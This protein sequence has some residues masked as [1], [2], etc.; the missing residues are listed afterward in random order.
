MGEGKDVAVVKIE[1]KN[2]PTLMLG[3]SDAM[4]VG[5]RLYVIGYPAA[6][7]SPVL[8]QKS[9]LEP[10]TNDGHVSAKKTA[11][12]GAPILQTNASTTHG[13]SGGPVLNEKGEVIGLLTFPRRHREQP[14][15]PGLQLHRAH[16][17]RSGVRAPGRHPGPR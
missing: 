16:Q 4:E 11:A 14:G 7:D 2:A 9:E 6:G 8:D 15:S 13:N 1:V 10:T 12:D 17:H 3:D 5:D